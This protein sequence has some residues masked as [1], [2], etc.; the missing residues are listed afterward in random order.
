MR[1]VLIFVLIASIIMV[2]VIAHHFPRILAH[3]PTLQEMNWTVR[4]WLGMDTPRSLS[5]SEKGLKET[6]KIL[7]KESLADEEVAEEALMEYHE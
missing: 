5:L 6:E 1:H 2:F 7:R 4:E 3:Y